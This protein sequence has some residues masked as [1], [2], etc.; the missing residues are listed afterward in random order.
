VQRQLYNQVELLAAFQAYLLYTMM[1]FF[2]HSHDDSPL[3]GRD[4]MINLQEIACEVALTGLVCP[5]ELSNSR[6]DWE[7]WIIASSKRRTLFAMYM[8]E[9]VVDSAR[10]IPHFLADELASLP[11]PSSRSLWLAPT[12]E[13]WERE[14]NLHLSEWLGGGLQIDELWPQPLAGREERQKRINR[15][16]GSVDEFGMMLYALTS[17]TH[18]SGCDDSQ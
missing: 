5:A 11:A 1:A 14:Y 9:G 3:A 4:I 7:S 13:I 8:F 2:L 6:P 18:H 15:W 17:F 12:R 16:L 10:G